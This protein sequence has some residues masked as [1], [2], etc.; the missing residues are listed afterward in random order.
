[1]KR[2]NVLLGVAVCGVL[3]AGCAKEQKPKV[4]LPD[5]AGLFISQNYSGQDLKEVSNDS[6][7]VY[8]VVLTDATAIEFN[9]DGMWQ[10]VRASDSGSV[11]PTI[12]PIAATAYLDEIYSG[13]KI[14]LVERD[15]P[16]GLI[17][18]TLDDG[19]AI[20]FSADGQVV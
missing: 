3:L 10:K 17:R 2:K 1:M 14:K 15:I 19:L 8:K 18:V 20:V 4:Q 11:L 16:T 12:L 5:L 9:E 7:N 6:A 13:K